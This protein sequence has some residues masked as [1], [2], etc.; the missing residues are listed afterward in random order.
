[1]EPFQIT[2]FDLLFLLAAGVTIGALLGAWATIEALRAGDRIVNSRR[3]LLTVADQPDGAPRPHLE[4][5][6]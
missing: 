5:A 6:S 3:Q 2:T 4:V 1:M